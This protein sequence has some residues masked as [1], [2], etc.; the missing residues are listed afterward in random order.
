MII[1]ERFVFVHMHKTGGQ[2]LNAIIQR[3]IPSYQFIGYHYPHSEIPTCSINLPIV[4]IVRNPWDWYISWYAFNS[5]PTAR[6]PLFAIVSDSGKAD[7]KTTITNLVNLGSTSSSSQAHRQ[8]LIKVLPE[9]L[10]QNNGVGLTKGDIRN[11]VN[12]NMGYYSWMFRR[13]LGDYTSAQLHIGRFENLQSDFLQIMD[14]LSVEQTP[15]IKHELSQQE[16]KNTSR[17]SHYSHYYDKD[18]QNLLAEKESGLIQHFDYKFEVVGPSQQTAQAQINTRQDN[19]QG[20]KKLLGRASNYLKLGDDYNVDAIKS[21][22][23]AVPDEK[24]RESGREKRFDIHRH[25]EA[26]LLV[27]FEDFRF[28][29]PEATALYQHFQTVV[30]P[31]VDH[32]ANYYQDNGFVVRMIFAKLLPGGKIP[33]HTDTG[34]SLLNCHRVHIPIITNDDN[35]FY[36]GGELKRM[37]V[38]ELW[39]INNASPHAVDNCSAEDRVHLI[40]D[41]MPNHA[42]K[43]LDEAVLPPNQNQDTIARQIDPSKLNMMIAD[44][45]QMHKSGQIKQAKSIY[46]TVLDFEPKH[47]NANN[48][49]G[50]LCVQTGEFETAI[51]HIQTALSVKSDDAQAH[52]NI[53]LAFKGLNLKDKAIKHFQQ[54]INLVPNNPGTHNN[55]GNMYKEVGQLEDAIKCYNDALS[56]HPEYHEAHHNLGSTLLLKANY[57]EAVKSLQQALSLRPNLKATHVELAKAL[58]GLQQKQE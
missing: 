23:N 55:L 40:I 54:A 19:S 37:Q 44:A 7:L 6:S 42:G 5:G 9:T 11:F 16:R 4:G 15:A 35:L 38:G 21:A 25:T 53:A 1:T 12:N 39:E 41:W 52:A 56:L 20:F 34:Y 46:R 27:K 13:M 22:L 31:L 18:L 50:L 26:L 48:L 17:H 24:W 30:Q 3:T 33:E 49:L 51:E 2:S 47:L 36:V 10:E 29:D 43:P 28:T 32:I 8:Q 14:S 45:Y 58:Q 57:S